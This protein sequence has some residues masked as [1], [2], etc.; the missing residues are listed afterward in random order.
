MRIRRPAIISAILALSAAGSILIGS[1]GAVTG[2]Q[3]TT[4]H[5]VAAAHYTWVHT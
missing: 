2:A 5:T 3:G 4:T 1:S